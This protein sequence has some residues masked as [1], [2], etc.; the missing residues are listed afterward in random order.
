MGQAAIGSFPAC[1][2]ILHESLPAAKKH[3]N[4]WLCHTLFGIR[5]GHPVGFGFEERIG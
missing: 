5:A 3:E 4:S 2:T 1:L